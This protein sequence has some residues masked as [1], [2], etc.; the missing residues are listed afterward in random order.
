MALAADLVALPAVLESQFAGG[1][2][3]VS[4]Y[5]AAVTALQQTATA[6]VAAA[7]EQE[8][9]PH[10]FQQYF[11]LLRRVLQD[12]F[13]QEL[14]NEKT[15]ELAELWKSSFVWANAFQK[16][17][18]KYKVTAVWALAL[19]EAVFSDWGYC[20]R[21][22]WWEVDKDAFLMRFGSVPIA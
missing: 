12:D 18:D 19:F 11:R 15:Q 5:I 20:E 2:P 13:L 22:E 6:E 3:D 9:R 14:F 16:E 21:S 4:A 17:E 8:L 10:G 7:L 1:C